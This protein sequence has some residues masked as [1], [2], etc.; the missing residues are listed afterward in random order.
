[1]CARKDKRKRKVENT[2]TR[3]NPV[4]AFAAPRGCPNA[5]ASGRAKRGHAHDEG[6]RR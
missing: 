1:M 2:H 5:A 4:L 6:V 3:V